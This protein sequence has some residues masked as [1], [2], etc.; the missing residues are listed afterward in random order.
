[1]R[2]RGITLKLFIMTVIFFVC[3]YGM[4]ILGQ[5]LFFD[6]FY[7]NQ[8]ESRVEKHLKSFG[9]DYTSGAW[10]NS[11]TSRELVSFMLSNKTQMVIVDLSGRLKS[12]DPFR[13]K[14]MDESGKLQVIPLS[15]FMNQY[16]D[17]LR[18]A[19]IAEGDQVTVQGERDE[20]DGAAD[21]QIYPFSIKK[22]GE[23]TV[24]E[25]EMNGLATVSG[26][27][28]ELVLPEQRIWN[29]RQGILLE[30]LDDWF[31][32]TAAQTEDLEQLHL[33]KEEWTAPWSGIRNSVIVLPV[34]QA[35]GGI[36]LLFTVTSLQDVKDSNQAL[37]WFFLYLGIGGFILILVLSLFFSKL[38]TR[39]LIKLNDIAGRMVSLDFTG[40][41][42]IR[43]KDELGSL[44]SSMFT[45]SQSLD[46][47]LG[48]LREANRQLV[49]EMEDK[50]RMEGIQ[51]EFFASASH[52]LKTPLSIIK[53]FAEGLEDGVNMGKQDHYIKVII[54]E[55][56]KMELLVKDMLDLAKLESGT[57]K[58]RRSSFMLSELTEKV[59]DKLIHLLQAKELKVV[60]IPANERPLYADA[61]RMEQVISNFLTNAIRHAEDSST[62]TINIESRN[63]A[64]MFSIHNLGEPIPEDQQEQ[65]WE[66][67]Y[68]AEVSRSRQNGGNGLGLS[69]AKVILDM[70]GCR[71]AVKNTAGGVC[72]YVTFEGNPG[73]Y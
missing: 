51:Q 72:F 68:R 27:V 9:A 50:R 2:R 3:F 20:E 71:Y 8:K 43:Q 24:G 16:G 18:A 37:R 12:E 40:G 35:D 17:I 34:Q 65:I 41:P 44:S 13:M 66:R 5:L 52:E 49:E 62:I 1:M 58:L 64:L 53:G 60:I 54:E 39:P 70:H 56:D 30:A 36:E 32:L 15:L 14:L 7:Q 28:I 25:G 10:G 45:L 57:V 26:T 69:I 29:P 22:Q 67:F 4:V 19:D 23:A 63:T 47:A 46:A 33:L 55:A 38:V 59:S 42:P 73:Q 31:P 48:E 11:R 21:A 61:A 6:S